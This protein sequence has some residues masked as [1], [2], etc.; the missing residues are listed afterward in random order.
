M[1]T[2]LPALWILPFLTA[3]LAGQD[4]QPASAVGG[5]V[6]PAQ[7]PAEQPA[8]QPVEG[9]QVATLPL[10]LPTA[11]APAPRPFTAQGEAGVCLVE[12]RRGRVRVMTLDGSHREVTVGQPEAIRGRAHLE[13]PAGAEARIA[14][15]GQASLTVWGPS[16]LEW[17]II[18][19]PNPAGPLPTVA[20]ANIEWILFDLAWMDLEVRRG[21]HRL[22]LP[23]DWSADIGHGAFALRGLPS[24]P[25]EM[26]HHAGSA[27]V[28]RWTGDASQARPQLALT[29]GS[30]LRIDRPLPGRADHGFRADAWED[31]AWPWRIE[32]DNPADRAERLV[33]ELE[34]PYF[35]GYPTREPGMSGPVN[36]VKGFADPTKVRLEVVEMAPSQ[37][38]SG[39]AQTFVPPAE[40]EPRRTALSPLHGRTAHQAP[41][42]ESH[43][44][45]R[46]GQP[47]V[48]PAQTPE[49]TPEPATPTLGDRSAWRNLTSSQLVGD[50]PL[51]IERRSDV[52]VQQLTSGRS[53]VVVDALADRSAWCF[54]PDGDWELQPGCVLVFEPS[55]KLKL[56]F[57]KYERHPRLAER[58]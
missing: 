4:P 16:A 34:T 9:L 37:T 41:R 55:G 8:A 23:G 56:G 13:V 30:S 20:P 7:A 44:R 48:A 40:P 17:Q 25:I 12:V 15:V 58:R 51:W 5:S 14:W 33:L 43:P 50:A 31:S 29:A 2:L 46:Q 57:G 39:L 52:T 38:S 11:G 26:R 45:S 54:A 3:P 27:A 42:V 6:A 22:R 28:L 1:R 18:A 53:Q 19:R 32:T 21:V 47:P 35:A 24:G 36:T 10:A 49:A